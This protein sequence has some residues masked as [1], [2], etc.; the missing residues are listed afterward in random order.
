MAIDKILPL[1]VEGIRM[2]TTPKKEPKPKEEPIKPE[3]PKEDAKKE[4]PKKDEK[5][6][7]AGGSVRPSVSRTLKESNKMKNTS[8]MNKLEELGRVNAEKAY[9]SKG[10]K[11]LAAEKKRVVG[12]LKGMKAGGSVAPSKMG[13]VAVGKP[14]MGSASKRAD[15]VAAKGKTKGMMPKMARGGMS[16]MAR[17]GMTKMARGGATKKMR[18]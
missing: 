12:E 6:Y 18:G 3:A 17:G 2:L 15:G 13:K 9:T 10:K 7:R 16:M 14:K 4:E 11:N 5:K 1:A 8:R